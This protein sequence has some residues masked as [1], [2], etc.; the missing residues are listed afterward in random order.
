MTN[1]PA[2]AHRASALAAYLVIWVAA[3]VLL[4]NEPAFQAEEALGG[5]VVLG[6]A[7]PGLA[8]LVTRRSTPL[9]QPVHRPAREVAL[10]LTWLVVIAVVLVVGF[11]RITRVTA[12]P[13]HSLVLLGLKL[14]TF[15]IAPAAL[16]IAFAPGSGRYRLPELAPS[17]LG[18]RQL[19]PALWMSLAI[20]AVQC[21]LGRGLRDLSHAGLP[22]STLLLG[23]PLVYAWLLVEVGV[24]EEFFF[25]ALLQTRLAATLRSEWA[26]LVAA[27][28]LFG[29][30]HA[31]G[32]YLRTGATL[33]A[34]GAHPS[35]LMAIG[36]SIV[37]TSLAGAFLG[38]LWLRTRNFAV[39]VLVHAAGDLLPQLL[40]MV[41]AFHLAR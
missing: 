24:V 33:E 35:L 14:A 15:V 5:F 2:A 12:E 40:P 8:L 22:L 31:P 32:F 17:A 25:R 26:G 38:V 21:V 9:P 19:R 37:L 39:V 7:L 29:L 27:T 13:L 41:T 23:I 4:R 1:S 10:L 20:L 6:L 3:F 36:Y 30:V 34:L 11:G 16:L 28:L 18:W